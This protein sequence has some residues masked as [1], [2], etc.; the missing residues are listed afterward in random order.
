MN[1][2]PSL[3]TLQAFEAAAR[4]GSFAAAAREL[5]ISPAA[6]SQ[7]IATLEDHVGRKLFHRIN[8]RS[9]LT[10]AG[11]EV[12]PRLTL[13][14]E[15]VNGVA[16]SLMGGAQ[17]ARLV[18]S[19]PSS[20]ATSW[21]PQRLPDF[22]GL[23][24]EA[25]IFVRG[26]E[27]PIAFERDL[28]DIRLSYGRF[29]QRDHDAEPIVTDAVH[30][31]CTPALLKKH[32]PLR[33]A[34]DLLAMPL[35]HTDWGPAAA[36]F[37]SWRGWFE[38]MSI[39]PGREIQR[40]LTVNSSAAALDLALAG[41]GIALCQGLFAAEAVEQ[42][43]LVRPIGRALELNQPYCLTVPLRS[44]RRAVVMAFRGWFAVECV[45][46]VNSPALA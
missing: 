13:A 3:R 42:G 36:A 10:E 31:V 1:A 14:F 18:V 9:V 15:E 33:D 39:A 6:V 28:I 20:V 26:E 5:S 24:G 37:P 17:R 4:T 19:V 38:A 12:L 2:L 8:R 43:R 32:G 25:D 34:R 22:I 44:A 40:G 23:H 16:R 30:P 41:L 27:E 11:R 45:K 7:L 35:I 21:L 29:D 46:S